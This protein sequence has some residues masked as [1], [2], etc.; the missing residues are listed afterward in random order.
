M[1]KLVTPEEI[2]KR[3][4]NGEN[5]SIIDVREHEEVAN[6]KIPGAK[7]IPLGQ[8]VLRK[9]EIDKAN[10]NVIVC[11]SGG[12]SKAACG[13]LAALGFKVVDLMYGMNNWQGNVE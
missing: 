2:M 8:L 11:Q 9:N 10:E 1:A 4:Q 5:V 7:H 12:R 6:G 13:I 3:L